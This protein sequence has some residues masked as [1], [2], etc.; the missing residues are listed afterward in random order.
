MI[1]VLYAVIRGEMGGVERF[2]DSVLFAHTDRVR[3]VVL[4]F[5]EGPW[6]DELR[7]R[8][9]GARPGKR[10]AERA[11]AMLPRSARD[12]QA[13]PKRYRAFELSV[14]PLAHVAGRIVLEMSH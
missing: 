8:T 11:G 4:S 10:A 5:R 12:H 14:V 7:A 2:L 9:S 3:P 6:L 1:N 13:A